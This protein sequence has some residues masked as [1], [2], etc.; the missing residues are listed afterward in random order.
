LDEIW[1]KALLVEG[2]K[3]NVKLQR[4]LEETRPVS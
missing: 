3:Y 2:K 4:Y 1:V